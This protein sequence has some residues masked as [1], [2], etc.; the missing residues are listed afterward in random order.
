M[1]G[2]TAAAP[3][4]RALFTRRSILM[5][6]AAGAGVSL[7]GPSAR[8]IEAAA[9]TPSRC[10]SLEDI[11]HVVILVM[12]NRSFDHFFGSYRG[13]AGFSDPDVIRQP[14]RAGLPVWYQYGWGPG[15]TAANA[16]DYLLPFRLDTT[17]PRSDAE[18]ANDITH[19]WVA[20]HLAWNLGGMDQWVTT[21]VASDGIADGPTT[22]GYYA[23]EDLSFLYGLADAFTLCDN[24]HCSVM[25]PTVPNRLY[26]MSATIDPDGRLGGGPVISNPSSGVQLVSPTATFDWQTMPQA[27]ESQ[28][29]SWKIYQVPGSQSTDSLTDNP[30]FFFPPF[31]DPSSLYFQKGML[32]AFPGDFQSDVVAGTL[33]QVSW[34]MPSSPLDEH[35]PAPP[36]LGELATT[37]QVLATLVS[38]P[39]VWERTVLFVT[40]DE[41]GGFFDH[42]APPTS[43]RGTPGEWLTVQ[44]AIGGNVAPGGATI[45]GP[46]GLGFR[47]P[48]LVLSPFSVGGLVCS[49]TFD[50]TSTLRFIEARFGVPVP[51][52]SDW[53]RSVTGD[54]T[55]AINFAGGAHDSGGFAGLLAAGPQIAADAQ[56]EAIQCSNMPVESLQPAP[57]PVPSPQSLPHQEPG[58]ARRPSGQGCPAPSRPH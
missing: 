14:S 30:M 42:V 12:E 37:R 40:Y 9:R 29:V 20:Q 34:L 32:P 54:L 38:N 7:A 18:C 52:L 13:V 50:H 55:S 25:G 17:D 27:L 46:I 24:Y 41:N 22:M 19:A 26:S 11:E 16:S 49:E 45:D 6:M 8:L 4:P 58:S 56:R 47:V 44:P 10:A 5:G 57:Y 23:R 21:H 33:P 43:P 28:G 15:D 31:R 1:S 53:R 39:A 35:P 3:G 51:N 36:P 2:M 48:M